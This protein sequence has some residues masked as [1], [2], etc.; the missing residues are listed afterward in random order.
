[1]SP[2]LTSLLRLTLFSSALVAGAW[3]ASRLLRKWGG[4]LAWLLVAIAYVKTAMW[5]AS[6]VAARATHP[7]SPE[8]LPS[9]FILAVLVSVMALGS[10]AWYAVHWQ[11][12]H[13]RPLSIGLV[14]RGVLIAYLGLLVVILPGIILLLS[15]VRW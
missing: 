15:G 5:Q 11:R 10:T 4:I 8:S 6:P 2:L 12:A 3:H 7:I 1:M 14:V 13:E 9:T